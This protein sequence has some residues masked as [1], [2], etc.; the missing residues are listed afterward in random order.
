VK[1]AGRAVAGGL[2]H[3]QLNWREAPGRWSIAECLAHLN[4]SV[5]QVLPA[6]DQTIAR[7]RARQET[8]AGPFRY[9]WFSR[10]II[11]SMEPPPRFRMRSP[12]L[13]RTPAAEYEAGALLAR[14]VAVR[15]QL[16]DRVRAADGLDLARAIVT[17]PANRLVR[18]PLGAYVAFLLAHERRH[19]WQARAVRAAG[20]AAGW[21]APAGARRTP[22]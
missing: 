19:L 17:S 8:G 14:F 21:P 10:M 20:E 18:M 1:A 5:S 13:F 11:G 12:K 7:A 22:R 9:G 2:S 15:E 16:A 3:S 4:Y 6:V